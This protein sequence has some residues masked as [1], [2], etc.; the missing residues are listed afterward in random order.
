MNRYTMTLHKNR[1]PLFIELVVDA[2]TRQEAMAKALTGRHE[3]WDEYEAR[4]ED[5]SNLPWIASVERIE[6]F[7]GTESAETPRDPDGEFDE[8][9]GDG[10]D[11][12]VSPEFGF[13]GRCWPSYLPEAKAQAAGAEIQRVL[14]LSTAHLSQDVALAMDEEEPQDWIY[15]KLHWGYLVFVPE[16]GVGFARKIPDCLSAAVQK[17]QEFGCTHV[18]FDRDA[19]TLD[20]LPTF[21]W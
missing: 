2:E 8:F 14:T 7:E 5:I 4:G 12:P 19:E 17:A 1:S 11:L 21:D 10:E 15:D 18:R 13:I 9:P 20:G 16:P 6:V 3:G